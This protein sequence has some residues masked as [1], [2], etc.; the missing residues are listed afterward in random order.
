M[1]QGFLESLFEGGLLVFVGSVLL[2]HSV[3][4]TPHLGHRKEHQGH[5]EHKE[6]EGQ[7][8]DDPGDGGT[9]LETLAD[10]IQE[11]DPEE[12]EAYFADETQHG[13]AVD[14]QRGVV[15]LHGGIGVHHHDHVEGTGEQREEGI[16]LGGGAETTEM[17]RY[18]ERLRK[19]HYIGPLKKIYE[20]VP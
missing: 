1:V 17:L 18:L 14:A 5:R 19:G 16:D 7:E 15:E 9:V 6:E 3:V 11:E 2:G 13:V 8:Q 10:V 4:E 20:E 12:G